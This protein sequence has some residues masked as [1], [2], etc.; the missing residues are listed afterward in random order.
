MTNKN[1]LFVAHFHGNYCQFTIMV[2]ATDKAEAR[3]IAMD[4]IAETDFYEREDEGLKPNVLK[5]D[6]WRNEYEDNTDEI[7]D[8]SNIEIPEKIGQATIIG[9]GTA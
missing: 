8:P 5:F 9:S 3:R 7:F 2:R 6:S 4:K 1:N